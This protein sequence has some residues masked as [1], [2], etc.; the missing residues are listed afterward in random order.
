MLQVGVVIQLSFGVKVVDVVSSESACS[1]CPL[2]SRLL[3]NPRKNFL[4]LRFSLAMTPQLFKEV[5]PEIRRE[6]GKAMIAHSAAQPAHIYYRMMSHL[7]VHP[8]KMRC[9]FVALRCLWSRYRHA[10]TYAC[11]F[12]MP[13]RVPSLLSAVMPFVSSLTL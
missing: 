2:V 12:S 11:H 1:L 4:P 13:T 7:T 9:T 3:C 6:R 8:L 5:K 10:A